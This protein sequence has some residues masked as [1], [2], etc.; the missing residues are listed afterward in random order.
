V[1]ENGRCKE[2]G[3]LEE[4]KAKGGTFSRLW[5]AQKFD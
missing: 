3:T 4:L 2:E 1:I 5:E